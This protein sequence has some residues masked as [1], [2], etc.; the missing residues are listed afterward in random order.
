[1]VVYKRG[2]IKEGVLIEAGAIIRRSTVQYL[3]PINVLQPTVLYTVGVLLE[4]IVAV[5]IKITAQT[6]KHHY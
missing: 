3:V 5:G 2:V 4:I 1:M 6:S